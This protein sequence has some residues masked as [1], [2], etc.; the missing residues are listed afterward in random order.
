MI[1]ILLNTDNDIRIENNDVVLGKSDL[2][3]Q[4]LLL[5]TH[6]G[7]FKES[8]VATVGIVNFLRDDDIE[9]MLHECTVRFTN[10]GMAVTK[11]NFDED[12]NSLDYGAYY[13]E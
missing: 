7:E 6:K 13:P 1:D 2:Q 9:G 4:E 8:P 5:V 3:H 12:S 11:M 10:D